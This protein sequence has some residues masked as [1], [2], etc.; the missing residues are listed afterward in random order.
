MPQICYIFAKI[1]NIKKMAK[2]RIKLT[3][4][5]VDELTSIIK[6]G[7]HTTQS[8][9]AAQ[10]LLNCDEGEHSL[11]KNT[12]QKISNILKINMRTIE[13]IKKKFVE[14]GM[15]CALE[16]AVSSR[17]YEKKVDGD[18]EAKMVQLCC[19]EPPEGRARWTVRLLAEKLVELEYVD[20]LSHVSVHNILKKTK[21]SP[22]KL[23]VG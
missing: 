10:V 14:G 15:E 23:K 12:H 8:Y 18:L 17:I 3:E 19:S 6:K 9:R 13:R 5:E 1:S 7:S 22:G 21:L 2:Y 16:R 11:G 20:Y 4:D